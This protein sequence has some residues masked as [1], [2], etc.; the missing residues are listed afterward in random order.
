M[1]EDEVNAG[2]VTGQRRRGWVHGF[3]LGT[4][5]LACG[6]VI[7]GVGT[8]VFLSQRSTHA[9]RHGDGMPERI[10]SDMQAKYGLTDAQK[11]QLVTVFAEHEKRFSQIRAEVAPRMDAEHE[12]LRQGVEAILT[13][14][15]AEQWRAE[16]E[17][18]RRPWHSR[19]EQPG[20]SKPSKGEN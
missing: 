10:A 7:G 3:V 19:H 8:A 1:P 15:Q 13:P 11:Q 5:I 14:G 17:R 16:F 4:V 6:I 18:V 12:A 2:P 20:G 9:M